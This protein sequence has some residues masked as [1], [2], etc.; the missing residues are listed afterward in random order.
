MSDYT[1]R[2]AVKPMVPRPA[3]FSA[4]LDLLAACGIDHTVH[5]REHRHL[6][7]FLFASNGVTVF[8]S[9]RV[10]DPQDL[11]HHLEYRATQLTRSG[12]KPAWLEVALSEL[13]RINVLHQLAQIELLIL[14]ELL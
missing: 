3:L 11:A 2:A 4:E 14:V 10:D 6:Q 5:Y 7:T 1:N 12:E 8:D 9:G 13:R